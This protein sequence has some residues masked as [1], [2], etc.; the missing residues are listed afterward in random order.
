MNDK[1]N[2][3][4]YYEQHRLGFNY[5]M[6]DIQASLGLSQLKKLDNFVLKRNRIYNYYSEIFSELPIKLNPIP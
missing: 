1:N 3:P 5:R 4:W 6:T 2:G